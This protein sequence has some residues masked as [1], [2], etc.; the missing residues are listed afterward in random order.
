MVVGLNAGNYGS[1]GVTD[2][3][4]TAVPAVR[5]DDELGANALKLYQSAGFKID[6]DFSGPYDSGGVGAMNADAWVASKLNF[7][8]TNTDPAKTP[9][10]EVLNE[11]GGTWF[12]GSNA[13]SQSNADAYR[14][15]L[16]KTYDAFHAEYGSSAPKILATFD[17]TQAITFGQR[18]WTAGSASFVDGIVVHP[19]GGTSNRTASALGNRQRVIDVHSLTGKPVY[20]TEVG[21]PTALGM[22]STGDSFQWS[23]TEQAANVTNFMD[24]ARSTGYVAAV[25]YFNY[26]DFGSNNLYG[27]VR[28]DGSHKPAYS[29]LRAEAL[30]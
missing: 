13:I 12:W 15:L 24:W 26:R 7:Y 20:V 23:E 10:I 3:E 8:K 21:W 9:W 14:T 28:G 1:S 5:L 2:V 18:W 6:L 30:K 17:G 11:P 22:S 19:Y 29:A 16:Q 27:V 25:M 4:G